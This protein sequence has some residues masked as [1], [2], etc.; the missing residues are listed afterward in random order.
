MK[1]CSKCKTEYP[2][3]TEYFAIHKPTKRFQSWCRICQVQ[4]YKKW[5]KNNRK[6]VETHNKNHKKSY[7]YTLPKRE[8]WRK[9]YQGVYGIFSEGQC[10]YI[11]QSK[12]INGRLHQHFFWIKKPHKSPKSHQ[13]LYSKLHQYENLVIGIIEE[14][15][16]HKEREKYYINKYQPLY[17]NK[18]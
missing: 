12:Q 5:A 3:T 2:A 10:L 1:Q 7:S 8:E 14:T 15:E 18:I 4:N 13:S 11:G 9:R 17:N 6:K 16:N